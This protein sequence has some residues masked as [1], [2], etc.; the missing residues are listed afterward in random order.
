MI[1]KAEFIKRLMLARR[2]IALFYGSLKVTMK[3]QTTS[4]EDGHDSWFLHQNMKPG[5]P[6]Y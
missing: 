4:K 5:F 2:S 6:L 3:K 1:L